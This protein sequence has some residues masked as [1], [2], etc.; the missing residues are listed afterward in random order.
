MFGV[1]PAASPDAQAVCDAVLAADTRDEL[2]RQLA[3]VRDRYAD[4]GLLSARHLIFASI[5]AA[6]VKL[7][8][9]LPQPP[10][11]GGMPAIRPQALDE[12]RT[13]YW[14]IIDSFQA[15]L[16]Q[17]WANCQ[18]SPGNP[19]TAEAIKPQFEANKDSTTQSG[20]Q[21]VDII[22]LV[23]SPEIAR[24]KLIETL[25]TRTRT[26]A[27]HL[28]TGL[29]RC[30]L[31]YVG[32]TPVAETKQGEL[33]KPARRGGRTPLAHATDP[34][35]KAR[36]NVYELVRKAKEDNPKWGKKEMH[37]HFK[38]H[39]DV[40]NLVT[41]AG[42]SFDLKLFNAALRWIERNPAGHITRPPE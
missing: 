20:P 35:G 25:T 18:A 33:G 30:D 19:M 31:D 16:A 11:G 2:L 24:Q 37:R 40:K 10:V 27:E 39:K 15:M 4:H 22:D 3:T 36:R 23:P 5:S 42:L 41:E 8:I 12:S 14:A 6:L 9:A 38:E 21:S 7:G 1:T 34:K 26:L 29:L 28:A 32:L 13:K 17:A